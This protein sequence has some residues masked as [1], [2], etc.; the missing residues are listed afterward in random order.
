MMKVMTRALLLDRYKETNEFEII[1]SNKYG[2]NKHS[3]TLNDV[4]D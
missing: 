4:N 1:V 3:F 2:M